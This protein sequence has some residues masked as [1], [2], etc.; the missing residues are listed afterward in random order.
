MFFICWMI[1]K[2]WIFFIWWTHLIGSILFTYWMFF[3]CWILFIGSISF[4]TFNVFLVLDALFIDLMFFIGWKFLRI[5]VLSIHLTLH[6]YFCWVHFQVKLISRC[7]VLQ[8]LNVHIMSQMNNFK[9]SIPVFKWAY[10]KT[11]ESVMILY[12]QFHSL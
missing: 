2:G 11:Y 8:H 10:M 6:Q 12:F 4:Y 3:M 9:A 1:F 5:W 7:W